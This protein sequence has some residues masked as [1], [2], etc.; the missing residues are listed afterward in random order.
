MRWFFYIAAA[1]CLAAA[2]GSAAVGKSDI[3]L[4]LAA[5]FFVGSL[6]CLAFGVILSG[7]RT[8]RA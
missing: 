5:V 4:T 7:A 1:V 2:A 8:P 6:N 3:Q